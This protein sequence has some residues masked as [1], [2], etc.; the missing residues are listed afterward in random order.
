MTTARAQ[1]P[2]QSGKSMGPKVNPTISVLES[3]LTGGGHASIEHTSTRRHVGPS[4]D[5][6]TLASS[7]HIPSQISTRESSGP[8]LTRSRQKTQAQGTNPGT[9]TT[10]GSDA[11]QTSLP[12]TVPTRETIIDGH[13]ARSRET[14]IIEATKKSTSQLGITV[15]EKSQY[16]INGQTLAPGSP[17]TLPGD[18]GPVTFRMLTLHSRTYIAVGTT[19]TVPLDGTTSTANA[20]A[21]TRASNGDFVL[22]GTTLASGQPI[23]IGRGTDRT[24][25]RLTSVRGTPAIVVNNATTELLGHNAVSSSMGALP[26]I[27]SLPATTNVSS[28]T[29]LATRT[30]KA[31]T[32]STPTSTS[33]GFRTSRVSG[34]WLI[35]LSVLIEQVW[36]RGG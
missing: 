29:I 2:K 28:D 22:H 10:N 35:S 13:T 19:K 18:D 14:D 24:T 20:L 17:I 33:K 27:T 7:S 8:D 21:F 31:S 3:I 1:R 9:T 12:P 30:A 36:L 26:S 5:P 15:D 11:S 32:S 6:A 25:L 16:V 23:T 4:K 34:L